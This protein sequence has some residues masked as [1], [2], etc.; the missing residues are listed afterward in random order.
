MLVNQYE[1]YN[2]VTDQL[3]PPD[4]SNCVVRLN[5]NEESMTYENFNRGVLRRQISIIHLGESCQTTRALKVPEMDD[6]DSVMICH[7]SNLVVAHYTKIVNA[8]FR[9]QY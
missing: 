8:Y 5:H 1:A 7:L 6:I 3:I 9:F 4:K 2:K